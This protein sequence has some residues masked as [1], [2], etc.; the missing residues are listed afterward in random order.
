MKEPE[1]LKRCPFCFGRALIINENPPPGIDVWYCTCS[2]CSMRTRIAGT[3]EDAIRIWQSR[4]SDC[5]HCRWYRGDEKCELHQR[6]AEWHT[7][8]DFE[9]THKG[10]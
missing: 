3:R 7:C 4:I 9:N 1:K 8:K 5:S 2:R 10:Q 6:V